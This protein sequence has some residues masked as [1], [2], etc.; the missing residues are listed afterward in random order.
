MLYD[1]ALLDHL[2]LVG[3][4]EPDQIVVELAEQGSIHEVNKLLRHL[5]TNAQPIAEEFPDNIEQWLRRTSVL[6]VH[7]DHE[8]MARGAAFFMEHGPTIALILSTASLVECYA[9]GKGCRALAFT[10]RLGQNAYRRIAETAQ[11]LLHVM[12]PGAFDEGG[13]G[14]PA[15]QKVRLMHSAVR[16]LIRETDRWDEAEWGVPICTEDMLGT[17]M[18]FSHLVLRGLRK[19]GTEIRQEDAEDY[20]YM[21]TIFGEMMGIPA[22]FIPATEAEG[23]ALWDRIVARHHGATPQ[24]IS[25]TGALMEFH[26]D[27]M[28]GKHFDMLVPSLTRYL[29]GPQVADWMEI[30]RSRWDK[31]IHH[32]AKLGRALD[33]LDRA[34]GSFANPV[35]RIALS[36]LNRTFFEMN[37]YRRA[38]FTIPSQLRV[39]WNL[40]EPQQPVE[41]VKHP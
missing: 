29:V 4:P 8:R 32:S 40:L 5:I 17:L 15:L 7:T 34:S 13:G 1:D 27:V 30:P 14:I 6:P 20:F 10:Y 22:E 28:P 18:A 25:M 39:A 2:R 24:G 31:L 9:A 41:G 26:A 36:Y 38:G 12:S 23:A 35:D 21:W 16:R 11:F 33:M 19:L 3:D 37:D